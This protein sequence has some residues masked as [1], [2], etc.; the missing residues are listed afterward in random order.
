LAVSKSRLRFR[1]STRNSPPSIRGVA[2]SVAGP[3]SPSSA[4]STDGCSDGRSRPY[5][6][7]RHVNSAVT[8]PITTQARR[9]P[10][11]SDRAPNRTG[12]APTP[13][14]VAPSTKPLA[15]ARAPNGIQAATILPAAGKSGG[16]QDPHQAPH[17][18]EGD[19]GRPGGDSE[20]TAPGRG[21][22]RRRAES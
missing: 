5:Q 17:Q 21:D 14:V 4:A 7:H 11:R 10:N 19:E 3:T 2:V 1:S 16:R 18:Q 12:A 15:Q 20:T 6:A 8:A 13:T 22:Q 9:H